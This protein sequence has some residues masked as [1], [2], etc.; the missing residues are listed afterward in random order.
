MI[1]I[2]KFDT[3]ARC[4]LAAQDST[5]TPRT[6]VAADVNHRRRGRSRFTPEQVYRI[7]QLRAEGVRIATLSQQYGVGRDAIEDIVNRNTYAWV[8]GPERV[9]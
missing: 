3:G 7:R 1:D 4:G 8:M 2:T 5:A 9:S 6:Q